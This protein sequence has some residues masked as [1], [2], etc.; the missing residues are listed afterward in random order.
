MRHIEAFQTIADAI[1]EGLIVSDMNGSFLVFNEEAVRILGFGSSEVG[2]ERWSETYGVYNGIGLLSPDQLPLVRALAGE[3]VRGKV[4]YIR[5]QNVPQGVYVRCNAKPIMEDGQRV[6]AV[7]TFSDITDLKSTEA[8]LRAS[9]DELRQ[10]AYAASHDLREPLAKMKAFGQRLQERYSDVLDERGNEYLDI[11]RSAS[12][13]MMTLIDDLLEYSR[14]GRADKRIER[15][16]LNRVMTEVVSLFSERLDGATIQFGPDLPVVHG[17]PVQLFTLFQNLLSNA[18]KFR[19]PDLPPTVQIT[20]TESEDSFTIEVADNGIGF[21][22]EHAERI[23]RI[24][25]RLHTRFD[26]PGTGVG[27]ALCRRIVERHGGSITAEG[28]PGEG[29]TFR[30]ILPK[31]VV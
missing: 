11:M 7:V 6:G 21:E 26:Y 19:K 4:L 16:D 28:R 22:P 29:A 5:N 3:T 23:F 24:F 25:E 2:P 17:D 1:G 12:D 20:S 13:R 27:L 31:G 30:I 15:V 8:E 10:F 9:N 18:L 14:V